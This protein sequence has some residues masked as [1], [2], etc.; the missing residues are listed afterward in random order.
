M[1]ITTH[2][3]HEMAAMLDNINTSGD[4]CAEQIKD[5]RS[6]IEIAAE[7]G[8]ITDDETRELVDRTVRLQNECYR[9]STRID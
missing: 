9:H 4:S 1:V 6:L 8:S 2:F 3:A 7:H 5:I